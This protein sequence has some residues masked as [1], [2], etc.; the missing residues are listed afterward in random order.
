MTSSGKKSE[1]DADVPGVG[2]YAGQV[3]LGHPFLDKYQ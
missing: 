3:K 1:A 2:L